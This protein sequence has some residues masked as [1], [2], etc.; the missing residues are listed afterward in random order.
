[1]SIIEARVLYHS[2]QLKL[3]HTVFV[4]RVK[5]TLKSILLLILNHFIRGK[6][7]CIGYI[8]SGINI[9]LKAK[10]EKKLLQRTKKV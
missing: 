4:L 2:E 3:S 6:F 7:Y 1:M 9:N 5:W 8:K 10:Y